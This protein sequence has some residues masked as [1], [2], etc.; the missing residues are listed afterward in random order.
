MCTSSRDAGGGSP[1]AM[2]CRRHEADWVTAVPI[3]ERC[4]SS[5]S[6]PSAHNPPHPIRHPPAR[7][8]RQPPGDN[9]LLH[10]LEALHTLRVPS[11]PDMGV[12]PTAPAP[13]VQVRVAGSGAALPRPQSRSARPHRQRQ[14]HVGPQ[15]GIAWPPGVA[16]G[17]AAPNGWRR[18]RADGETTSSP[19]PPPGTFTMR[20]N[21]PP[22]QG[23]SPR[24]WSRSRV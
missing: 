14:P 24:G 17:A 2:V 23:V 22:F 4:A 1:V 5:L 7:P 12:G 20:A 8:R 18:V 21:P 16:S 15:V 9:Q 11:P 10:V 3:D 19:I 6:S 13:H